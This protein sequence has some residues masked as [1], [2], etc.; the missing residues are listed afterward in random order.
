MSTELTDV[1]DEW[2]AEPLAIHGWRIVEVMSDREVVNC[3]YREEDAAR[4]VA[5]H[6]ARAL[7]VAA[8]RGLKRVNHH[9]YCLT[10][11]GGEHEPECTAASAALKT[12]GEQ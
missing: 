6:N 12:T 10:W 8:L 3:V 1:K 4:V 9:C 7:L 11:V 5:D 2:R